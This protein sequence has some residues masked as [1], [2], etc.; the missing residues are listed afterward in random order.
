MYYVQESLHGKAHPVKTDCYLI[1][2][3]GVFFF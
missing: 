3:V 2:G 1:A